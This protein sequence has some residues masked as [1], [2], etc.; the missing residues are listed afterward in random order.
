MWNSGF[1]FF[2]FKHLRNIVPL[3]SVVSDGKSTVTRMGFPVG[4][5]KCYFSLLLRNV[6]LVFVLVLGHGFLGFILF[7]VCSAS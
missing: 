6:C 4:K 5:S 2:F 3:P 7:K 1:F